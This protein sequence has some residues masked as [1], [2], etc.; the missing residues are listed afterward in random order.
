[1]PF[2]TKSNAGQMRSQDPGVVV[3]HTVH[4]AAFQARQILQGCN[5]EKRKLRVPVADTV[6]R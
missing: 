1:M 6:Y 2:Q 4:L 5:K 3:K